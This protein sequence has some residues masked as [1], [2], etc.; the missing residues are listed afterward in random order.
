MASVV[1]AILKAQPKYPT[2]DIDLFACGSTLG[3]LLRFARGVD[4]AFRFTVEIVQDTVFFVRKEND[5]REIIEGIHGFGHTFPE[6]YTT[7]EQD[8]KGSDTHQRIVRYAFGGLE[9]LVRFES[10]GYIKE[11]SKKSNTCSKSTSDEDDLLQALQDVALSTSS[12]IK[13]STSNDLIVKRGGSEVPQNSIFDLKTRS[14]RYKKDID[15]SDIYPQL[16]LKQIP[17][18]IVAYHDG[19]GL[20]QDIRV[21]NVKDGVQGWK[22]DNVDGIRRFAELL[23]KILEIAKNSEES[24][25]DVYCPGADRL[26]IREPFGPAPNALPTELRSC[27]RGKAAHALPTHDK[28]VASTDDVEYQSCDSDDDF[29]Y[30]GDHEPEYTFG[31]DSDDE[32]D[33]TACSAHDCGYCGKCSY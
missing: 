17:N 26:E 3:N 12:I 8:V 29:E 25:L 23:N 13:N 11:S 7:W 1:R 22:K 10:D 21:Q 31:V 14:G 2:E 6:N 15:M 18:F 5:P 4:K 28:F 32:P 19:A 16:W 33:Y 9:C 24:V 30:S 27:W 20:F